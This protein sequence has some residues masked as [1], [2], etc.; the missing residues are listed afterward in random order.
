MKT[1]GDGTKILTR[2]GG[3]TEVLGTLIYNTSGIKDDQPCLA[4]E[5]ASMS[6]AGHREVCFVGAW[7]KVPVFE[8][9]AG[10]ERKLPSQPWMTWSLL[11]VGK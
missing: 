3:R 1:E 6:S 8:K 11:R 10:T 9:A 4:V 5:D 7:W 2:N